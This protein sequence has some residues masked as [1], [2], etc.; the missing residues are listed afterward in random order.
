MASFNPIFTED[1]LQNEEWRNIAEFQDYYQVSN[2]GRIRRIHQNNRT[3]STF[4]GKILAPSFL[5]KYLSV[6]PSMPSKQRKR[7]YV[8]KIVATAFIGVRPE[9]YEI[10]HKDT[11]KTNNR[12]SNLEYVTPKGNMQ[13][14]SKMGLMAA[15][16]RHY[17]H[18]HPEK[19]ARGM[20]HG[21]NTKPESKPFG[22]KGGLAKL[23]NNQVI[24]IRL[25][26][27][28]GGTSCKKLGNAYGVDAATIH[29]II[30][31]K[32]WTHI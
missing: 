28:A 11:V 31:R 30:I 13:H 10:N 1:E 25:R 3:T 12:A 7:I 29:R 16:E 24:E 32:T 22:E 20:R 15:G 19:T 26:Y 17:S 9:G 27:A 8:H 2:L 21:W 6:S 5:R 4:I 14:A 23:T 18:L